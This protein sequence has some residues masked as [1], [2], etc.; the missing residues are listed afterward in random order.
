MNPVFSNLATAILEN[1]ED[2]LT[3]NEEAHDGELWDLF[4]DELGLTVEQAD[5]A[6][7]LRSRYRCEIFIARQSPLYQTNTITFD[8][9]AKKLVAG[10]ALS[11]DQILEVYRT[12]LKSRPGQRL[13]LGPHWAAG[14]NQEGD[15]Y[16]TPLPH[17]DTNAKFEVFDFDRDAFVDGHWQCE[18]QEQTQ[19]AIDTPVF[20]K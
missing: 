12:L 11:F 16:C 19:S 18:T 17:C 20:I 14:L 4:I 5:A 6:I 9:K 15:L 13:K 1:V 7:A 10:E 3:N 8:P 2:Q